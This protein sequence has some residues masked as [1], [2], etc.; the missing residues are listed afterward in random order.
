MFHEKVF[1]LRDI[2][3]HYF[4]Q[5]VIKCQKQNKTEIR[6]VFF[7]GGGKRKLYPTLRMDVIAVCVFLFVCMFV[8]FCFFD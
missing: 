6:N 3:S 7:W 1:E 5:L 4:M 8:L 2:I